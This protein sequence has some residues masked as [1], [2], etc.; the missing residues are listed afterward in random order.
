MTVAKV[1]VTLK[2]DV[3]DPQ[4]KAVKQSLEA[5]GFRHLRDVRVGKFLELTFENLEPE[6]VREEARRMCER[7][8]ANPVIENYR[9]EVG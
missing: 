8:L 1:Y 5:L 2:E 4:G 9:V 6:V 7:L 3:L